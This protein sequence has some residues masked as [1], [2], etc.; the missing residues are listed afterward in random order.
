MLLDAAFPHIDRNFCRRV[1]EI[2]WQR[3]IRY[4]IG[5]VF[6]RGIFL[7]FLFAAVTLAQTGSLGP[8][9]GSRIPDFSAPDQ[10]GV[11]QNLET[12]KGPKGLMLVF[13]RSADW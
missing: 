10:H 2:R 6:V 8:G 9:V 11:V 1:S 4:L 5:R 12:L 13:F 7:S 3:R